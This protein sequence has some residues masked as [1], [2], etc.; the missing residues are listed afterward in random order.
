MN[1]HDQQIDENKYPRK[2]KLGGFTTLHIN[3]LNQYSTLPRA[4]LHKTCT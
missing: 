4:R 1:L 3:N 2:H